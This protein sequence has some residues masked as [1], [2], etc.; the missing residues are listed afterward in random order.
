MECFLVLC[1]KN[2]NHLQLLYA[3]M[4]FMHI[5]V[6][7]ALFV[8]V[9]LG[10]ST[11]GAGLCANRA[12]NFRDKTPDTIRIALVHLD[13]RPGE[14]ARNHS[15]IEAAIGVVLYSAVGDMS[16]CSCIST[17]T[18]TETSTLAATAKG[19]RQPWPKGEK[20]LRGRDCTARLDAA[21]MASSSVGDGSSMGISR[22]RRLRLPSRLRKFSNAL[23]G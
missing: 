14:V 3:R 17:T 16:R 11:A 10:L 6:F 18:V 8:L 9:L 12:D 21:R 20:A 2:G 23:F 7:S 1:K 5:R 4:K 13:A 19:R 15:R 22:Y